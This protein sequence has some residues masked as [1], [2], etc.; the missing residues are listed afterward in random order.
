M[1]KLVYAGRGIWDFAA[2]PDGDALW[3]TA[4][5]PT[6]IFDVTLPASVAESALEAPIMAMDTLPVL[7]SGDTFW[8]VSPWACDVTVTDA[9]GYALVRT[10]PEGSADVATTVMDFGAGLGKERGALARCGRNVCGVFTSAVVRWND[11]GEVIEVL[12]QGAIDV[13][14][15]ERIA[16]ATG[17]AH[18]L[19]VHLLKG[20]GGAEGARVV[21][22]PHEG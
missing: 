15:G 16:G 7:T 10:T 12:D 3:V 2:A 13:R 22:I 8:S 20:Q 18:G 4:C 19:Y 5:G 11:D 21:F 6:G 1:T 9:C 14:S 17:N